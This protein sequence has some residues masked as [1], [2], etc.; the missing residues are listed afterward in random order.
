MSLT[1]RIPAPLR[2]RAGGARTVPLEATSLA[3]LRCALAE[4]Y[5][6]GG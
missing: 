4:S 6:Y 1:V 3:E 2:G 5:P